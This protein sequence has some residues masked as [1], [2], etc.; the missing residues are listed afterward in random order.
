MNEFEQR[1]AKIPLRSIPSEWRRDLL[2]TADPGPSRA[3]HATVFDWMWPSP[4]AWAAL[5]LIWVGLAAA[6]SFGEPAGG[7]SAASTLASSGQPAHEKTPSLLAYQARA[8]LAR[9]LSRTP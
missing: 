9:E 2:A 7:I 8:E 3:R 4:L 5:A 1:L 6:V